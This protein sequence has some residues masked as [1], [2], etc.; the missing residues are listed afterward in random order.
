M[1]MEWKMNSDSHDTSARKL[2][3]F[4]CHASEDKPVVR[5]I[6]Q[7]FVNY[8]MEPWLDEKNL[9]PGEHWE[10]LIPDVIRKCDIILL[11]L[12]RTFLVKEGY[13]HYEVHVI[14]EAA[15][16]KPRDTIYLIPFRLDD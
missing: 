16:R 3:V 6:Y 15:K 4:L 5:D 1:C 8:N 7:E 13:G 12:S 11:C 10:Q 2:R 14:L 9:L